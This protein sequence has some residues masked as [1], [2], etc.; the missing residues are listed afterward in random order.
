MLFRVNIVHKEAYMS[1]L[2]GKERGA[3]ILAG[4][5]KEGKKSL[6]DNARF[7]G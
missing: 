2:S 7:D 4:R 3:Q 5:R 1:V 6:P